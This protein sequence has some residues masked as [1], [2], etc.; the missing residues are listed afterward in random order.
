MKQFQLENDVPY[1]HNKEE[2]AFW[3]PKCYIISDY[4]V[5]HE[6]YDKFLNELKNLMRASYVIH[7]CRTYPIKFKFTE[8]EVK[9]H[10]LEFRHFYINAILWRP[11]VDLYGIDVLD[12]SFIMDCN[13]DIT[14]IEP[15]INKKLI[16]VLREYNV[17][18]TTINYGISEVLYNLRSISIDFSVIMGL[19]FSAKDFIDMYEKNDEVKDIMEVTFDDSMQPHDIET[20]LHDLEEREI[21]IYKNDKENPIGA[22][23]RA[24]AGV[25]HKQFAEFTIADG[26]KP[27]LDGVTVP[28]PIENSTILKGLDRAS[29]LYVAALGSRK[30]LVS[31][32]KVMGRAGHFGKIVLMTARTL[33]MST[34]VSDCGTKHLVRYEV[35]NK[36]YLKKLNGKYYKEY[37]T[38]DDLKLL[39]AERDTHLIGKAIYVRSATTCA[40]GDQVCPRCVGYTAITNQDIADGLSAFESDE[41]TKVINQNILSTKHLLT[42]NSEVIK[43]NDEFYKF[44]TIIGG[45]INPIINDNEDYPDIE[46]WAIY[47]RPE[48][49]IKLE[50]Y[51]DDS[52][53]N[54]CIANGVF[55]MRNTKHPEMGDIEIRMENEKEIFLS[56]EAL[57][58]YKK[59]NGLISFKNFDDDSKIFEISVMNQELTKSLYELMNLLNKENK[60]D[61]EESIEGVSQRFLDLL[62]ESGID[63]NVIAAELILNRLIRSEERP[64]ERPDFLRKNLE[65]YKIYTVRKALERNGS[66]LIGISFQDIKRQFL[67]DALYEDRTKT[68]FVD[69]FYWTEVPTDNLKNYME[70]VKRQ[71]NKK[72]NKK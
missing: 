65:P 72:K 28:L 2:L 27:T 37:L 71:K 69:P 11:F 66:P 20:L 9:T 51:D 39:N 35:K 16:T 41:I 15:Y 13:K 70:I 30:S 31:N 56:E 61:I 32:K 18:S 1:I 58:E 68:S 53:Y 62:V 55:Y 40:L 34:T 42:T 29:Y 4:L 63:A 19:N 14:N 3:I 59:G 44:F 50:E 46:D 49:I 12:E 7:A 23:L 38:D 54:T 67:S 10:K 33:S 6:T 17:E 45:E 26:L 60:D 57:E 64:Y 8:K 48:D 52:A 24:N 22:L 43:F 47:I 21:E 25:K 5:D 36:K